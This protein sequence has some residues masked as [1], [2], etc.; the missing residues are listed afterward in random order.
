MALLENLLDLPGDA[1]FSDKERAAWTA[2]VS[3]LLSAGYRPDLGSFSTVGSIMTGAEL[4][5]FLGI[6]P[7]GADDSLWWLPLSERATW[8][9]LAGD[10]GTARRDLREAWKNYG[11]PGDTPIDSGIYLASSKIVA[12]IG[13]I[14]AAVVSIYATPAAGVAVGGA[15]A[16]VSAALADASKTGGLDLDEA[17]ILTAEITAG[18]CESSQDSE[19]CQQALEAAE[20]LKAL[21]EAEEAEEEAIEEDEED[22]EDEEEAPKKSSSSTGLFIGLAL[23][24]GLII[25]K[26]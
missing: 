20:A 16:A 19:A 23:I 22:E 12:V 8:L 10:R 1:G 9:P 4:G 14:A 6:T 3:V 7:P 26:R 17:L 13:F 24:I 21:L 25:A 11:L 15:F 5:H 2:T 18:A